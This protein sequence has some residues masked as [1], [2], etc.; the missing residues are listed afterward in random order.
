MG[1]LTTGKN[2]VNELLRPLSARLDSLTAERAEMSRLQR[3]A[4]TG[5]FEKPIFVI[6]PQFKSCDPL[7]IFQQIQ[8]GQNRFAEIVGSA[9]P[10]SFP[11]KNDY[12]TTPD[13]EVLYAIVQLYR[14]ARIVE[15][16]SG[17][18]TQ[19]FRRAIN[20]ARIAAHLTSIDPKPRKE[21]SQQ[22]D[23]VIS[24]QVETVGD[25]SLFRELQ[26]SDILFI[27]SSHEIKPGN[28]LLYLV[29][30][31][32]PQ[33]ASGVLIHFHDIFL[34]YEYPREWIIENRWNWTEQY[35][36]Q[37]FLTGNSSFEV[38]WPGYYLQRDWPGFECNFKHWRHSTARS[39]WLQ[40]E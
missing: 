25:L 15:V 18:S 11:L 14:P 35:L 39:L 5:H 16:G 29:F 1:F 22:S 23:T 26:R 31:V 27:D 30:T 28:D 38:L 8:R 17:Y 6:L 13:A 20:D 36:V 10:D 32:L 3:L 33:L 2:V 4:R 34:P 40:K 19:L 21:I 9:R 7:P 37:A 12:F 24:E